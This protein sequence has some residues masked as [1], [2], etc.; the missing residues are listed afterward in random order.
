[1]MP[2][3]QQDAV[4]RTILEVAEEGDK[5]LKKEM[6]NAGF[7]DGALGCILWDRA[8]ANAKRVNDAGGSK[9]VMRYSSKQ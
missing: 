9:T 8:V 5:V 2:G 6:G 3:D 1:M 7:N 4:V